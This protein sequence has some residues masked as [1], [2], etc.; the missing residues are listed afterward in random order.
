MP[1]ETL[2]IAFVAPPVATVSPLPG[3]P[4]G[5]VPEESLSIVIFSASPVGLFKIA[6][7]T[8]I[9]EKRDA[10]VIEEACRLEVLKSRE[11]A[12]FLFW[13]TLF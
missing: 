10:L 7:V 11:L 1:K 3:L 8:E 9:K 2:F 4:V 6:L 13:L 12:K 5:G